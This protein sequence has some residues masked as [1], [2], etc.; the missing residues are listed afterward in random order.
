LF[1][2]AKI[3]PWQRTASAF[4]ARAKSSVEG[5]GASRAAMLLA[6]VATDA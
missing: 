2:P 4:T 3:D 5:A 1:L 6:R